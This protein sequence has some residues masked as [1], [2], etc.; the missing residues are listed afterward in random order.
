MSK[1]HSI[2]FAA[3]IKAL[4]DAGQIAD[5]RA[6]AKVIAKV[7]QTDNPRFDEA[8]FYAVCNLVSFSE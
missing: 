5:A 8:R 7:A 4:V 6:S 1:K 2:Q 3:E